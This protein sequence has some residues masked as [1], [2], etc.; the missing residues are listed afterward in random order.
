[1]LFNIYMKPLGEIVWNVGVQCHQYADD[2][3]LYFLLPHKSEEAAS[4]L[5][6]CLVSVMDW[7]RVNKLKL[8]PKKTE[9]LL[10]SRK[11]DQGIGIQYWMGL[12]PH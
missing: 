9:L 3:Q 5:D 1:M 12:Y 2:I 11:A 4:A 10:V 8:K 6:S 7:M